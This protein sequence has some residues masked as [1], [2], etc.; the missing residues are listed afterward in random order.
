M[1]RPQ[2]S[3]RERQIVLA[4]NAKARSKGPRPEVEP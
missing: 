1:N 3:E 2:D 4:L